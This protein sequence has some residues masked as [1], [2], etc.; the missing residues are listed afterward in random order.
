MVRTWPTHIVIDRETKI[1][2][3]WHGR[4]DPN[5]NVYDDLLKKPTHP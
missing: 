4:V 3:G 2:F 1:W 5:R